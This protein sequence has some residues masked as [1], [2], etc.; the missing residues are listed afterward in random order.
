M[1]GVI[2]VLSHSKRPTNHLPIFPTG[3]P[4]RFVYPAT[5]E[6]DGVVLLPQTKDVRILVLTVK[7]QRVL[8]MNHDSN[9]Y[10]LQESN[11]SHHGKRKII[12]KSAFIGDMLVPWRVVSCNLLLQLC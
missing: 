6:C 8:L 3:H 7:T 1:G 9:V 2:G 4:G 5:V 10:T 11:M 12:V